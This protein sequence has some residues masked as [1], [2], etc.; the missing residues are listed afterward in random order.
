VKRW[1]WP[2]GLSAALLLGLAWAF[3]PRAVAVDLVTVTRGPMAVTIEDTGETRVREVYVI[4]APIAGRML[5]I[6]VHAGDPITQNATVIA[7]IEPSDPAFRDARAQRE[8]E[9]GVAAAKAARDLAEASL[10]GRQAE[11]SLGRKDLERTQQ[12]FA[13]G[14]IAKAPL[15]RAEAEVEAL[16][17]AR[18]T[19]AAALRQR[20]IRGEHGGSIA[21]VAG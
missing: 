4:S 7:M 3:W 11:L 8:L 16:E 14:M 13:K 2:L 18:E 1:A 15:E 21:D 6:K 12:L 19:A 9:Y 17:A 5:R 20:G 10:K